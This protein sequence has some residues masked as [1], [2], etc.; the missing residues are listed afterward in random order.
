M[1]AILSTIP[2]FMIILLG[3]LLRVNNIVKQSWTK[4]LSSFVYYVSLPALITEPSVLAF[5]V[6]G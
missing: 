2:I 4:V 6:I 1:T 3:Y 5:C